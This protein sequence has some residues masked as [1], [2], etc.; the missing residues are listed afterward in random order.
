MAAVMIAAVPFGVLAARSSKWH[1]ILTIMP[2]IQSGVAVMDA[3]AKQG[4]QSEQ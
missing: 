4:N 1:V 3:A 2:H